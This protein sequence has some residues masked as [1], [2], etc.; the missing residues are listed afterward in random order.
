M[1][2]FLQIKH[3]KEIQKHKFMPGFDFYV[4]YSQVDRSILSLYR[5]IV[6][7]LW[8]KCYYAKDIEGA[9]MVRTNG[10]VSVS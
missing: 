9:T 2:Y 3:S 8:N 4:K 1:L 5:D 7:S 10:F 6:R